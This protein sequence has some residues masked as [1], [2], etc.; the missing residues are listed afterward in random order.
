MCLFCVWVVH[1]S[2]RN[3]DMSVWIWS[4]FHMAYGR[5]RLPVQ[6][7]CI[8]LLCLSFNEHNY[9]S[10]CMDAKLITLCV[11]QDVY[12]VHWT[13]RQAKLW[14]NIWIQQKQQQQQQQQR[15]N[16]NDCDVIQQQAEKDGS[17]GNDSN[18]YSVNIR[19]S[20]PRIFGIFLSSCRQISG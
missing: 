7:V 14:W 18:L 20:G 5:F 1:H 6:Y 9:D 11:V 17:V 10:H 12:S 4:K 13:G 8:T 19:I 3:S 15:N 16:N 2:V